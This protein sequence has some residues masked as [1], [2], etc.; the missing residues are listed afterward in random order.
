M[1]TLNHGESAG[2]AG[3]NEAGGC[4]KSC[5]GTLRTNSPKNMTMRNLIPRFIR[6][7][8][9]SLQWWFKKKKVRVYGFFRSYNIFDQCMSGCKDYHCNAKGE[10]IYTDRMCV[11]HKRHF[12]WHRH[13]NFCWT[14]ECARQTWDSSKMY[15]AHLHRSKE[16]LNSV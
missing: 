2:V 4:S 13:E 1:D 11:R 3:K 9:H 12:G 6:I 10:Y 5:G 16:W 15:K 7:R 14:D 8:W